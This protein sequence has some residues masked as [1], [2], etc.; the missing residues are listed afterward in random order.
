MLDEYSVVDISRATKSPYYKI[1]RM[2]T[3]K[4]KNPISMMYT[5]KLPQSVKE[6]VA[7]L[8]HSSLISY[9]LPD[10]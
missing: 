4:R 10:M 1:N 8:F 3:W 7:D 2:L 5:W 9:K 6:E